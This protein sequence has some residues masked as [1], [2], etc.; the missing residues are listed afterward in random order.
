M[1]TNPYYTRIFSAVAGSVAR[2]RSVLN[3][4]VLV[5]QGF[6]RIGELRGATKYQLACSDLTSDLE[7]GAQVAYFRV[8]RALIVSDVRASVFQ[9]STSG[10]VEIS[11]TVNGAN[12]L[13]GVLTI[14]ANE[15]SSTTSSVP[16]VLAFTTIDDDA[17]VIIGITSP[18]TSAKGLIVSII[19][20]IS[21]FL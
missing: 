14:D 3:E 13:T 20:A 10:P 4:F 15:T 11:I 8:Q 21:D 7:T 16:A 2:A 19:G 17:E 9:A 6:E 18:G 12:L 1:A 5:Q